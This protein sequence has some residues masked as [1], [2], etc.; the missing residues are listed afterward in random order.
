MTQTK[1]Q[2][3]VFFVFDG[4]QLLDYSGVAAVFEMANACSAKQLYTTNVVC[5][6]SN[7]VKASNSLV[8]EATPF[9]KFI[10]SYKLP[11]IDMLMLVGGNEYALTKAINDKATQDVVNSLC[12]MS[13]RKCSVCSGAFFLAMAGQLNG[14]IATTHWSGTQKL[15]ELFPLV[16]VQDH[17]LYTIDGNTLT[18]AGVTTGIDLA[19]EL[20]SQDHGTSLSA[21]VAKRL[22]VSIHRPGNSSQID[23]QLLQQNDKAQQFRSLCLWLNQRLSENISVE[24]MAEYMCMSP[25]NFSRKF[26]EVMEI[27]PHQYF[28]KLKMQHA[29]IMLSRGYNTA[30]ICEATGYINKHS[31]NRSFKLYYGVSMFQFMS[32]SQ[33]HTGS[34]QD[35]THI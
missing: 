34:A 25:R 4:C 12:D 33:E 2:H 20:V 3:I 27:A 18:S 23:S 14:K 30:Q 26:S 17:V 9:A 13:V 1:T 5:T 28:V 11:T 8:F 24:K 15:K 32:Y 10:A 31:L 35:N 7:K 21:K 19:L 6:S 29:K 22:V 16:K